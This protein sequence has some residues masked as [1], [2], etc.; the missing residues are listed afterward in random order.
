MREPG[1]DPNEAEHLLKELCAEHGVDPDLIEALFEIEREHELQER[2][3]G[4]F[5]KLRECL[6]TNGRSWA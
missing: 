2:R 1:K 4:I 5:G 6:R 3:H